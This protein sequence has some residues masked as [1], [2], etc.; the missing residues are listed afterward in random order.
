M[1]KMSKQTGII[2][3]VEGTDWERAV[4]IDTTI[5]DTPSAQLFEAASQA[6]EKEIIESENFNLGAILIVKK[7]KKTTKEFLVNAYICLNNIAKYDLA[8]S[9]RKNYK[10]ETGQDL[11]TDEIGYSEQ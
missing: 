9:L 1:D 4:Q 7:N 3:H 6:V 2:Y 8:E 10:A 5:F 11:A